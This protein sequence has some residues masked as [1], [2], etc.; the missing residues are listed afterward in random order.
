VRLETIPLI[1]GILVALIGLGFFADA[2]MGD[3][4]SAPQAERR[5]RMRAERHRRGE[6]VLGIGVL[7]M[8][9]ALIG[10]DSWRYTN[11]AVIAG[12]LAITAGA[13]YNRVY[14]RELMMFRGPARRAEPDG[15]SHVAPLPEGRGRIR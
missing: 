4:A 10:R 1:I 14:L 13:L 2:L 12:T 6:V 11:I 7:C 15:E 3:E 9:A 8:A 5:R